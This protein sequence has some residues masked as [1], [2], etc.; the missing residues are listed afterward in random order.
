MQGSPQKGDVMTWERRKPKVTAGIKTAGFSEDRS[1]F[2]LEFEIPS[3]NN[4]RLEMPSQVFDDL[5]GHLLRLQHDATVINPETG[6]RAGED[7]PVRMYRVRGFQLGEGYPI[8]QTQLHR[9][10][11]V[12]F[13][14]GG[15]QM[16]SWSR[17]LDADIQRALQDHPL[18]EEEKGPP[19]IH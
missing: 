11:M 2:G 5:L 17:A 7:I 16:L 14:S 15:Q 19:Q 8:N 9:T 10:M 18:S 3:G 6:A 1:I 13:D 4:I 12:R